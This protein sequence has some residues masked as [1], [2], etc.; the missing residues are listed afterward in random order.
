M[1]HLLIVS[2]LYVTT[3]AAPAVDGVSFALPRL[4]N[5]AIAGATGSGKSTLL[6]AIAGLV[7]P[8]GGA[9][10]FKGDRV[11]GPDEKLL[12][13]HPQIAY[14]SQHF[15]LRNNYRVWEELE[16]VNEMKE[17]EA[18]RIYAIC[19]V[20]HLLQR[21]TNQLSG[22]EKQRIV[23]ARLLTTK[24]QLFLL[25][26]PFS[27]LDLAHKQTMQRVIN[28]IGEQLG[29]TCMLVTHD[30]HDSLPWAHRVLILQNGKLIQDGTPKEV[31]RHPQN[32]YAAGLLG[33]F[34]LLTEAQ[35]A[36][37]GLPLNTA[38]ML[39]PEDIHIVPEGTGKISATIEKR[40]FYGS[41]YELQL[42][43]LDGPLIVRQRM[44]FN[45]VVGA[46]VDIA[47]E[48]GYRF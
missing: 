29:I 7:Q 43:A 26:E 14:L 16:C 10:L 15:E 39:R 19:E 24:P 12:P 41:H 48:P 37:F 6:K 22:G 1:E 9:I 3:P 4:Q 44:A 30:P 42:A 17:R 31:Y 20:D 27:N 45:P 21:R 5:V 25:D 35:A 36:A 18:A 11:F 38:Q 33:K 32:A 8:A 28:D 34:N 47:L 2:D 40:L 13:G 46:T 23:T